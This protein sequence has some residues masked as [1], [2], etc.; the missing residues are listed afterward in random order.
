MNIQPIYRNDK[1]NIFQFDLDVQKHLKSRYEKMLRLLL[2]H[3]K[4][5][6]IIFIVALL[7][8]VALQ[9]TVTVQK[10]FPE[11]YSSFGEVLR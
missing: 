5:D 2:L 3:V 6:R 7:E 11:S 4:L 8:S 9:N 10:S 1:I